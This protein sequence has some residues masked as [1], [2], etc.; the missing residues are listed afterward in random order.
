M[1]NA[2]LVV[3]ATFAIMGGAFAKPDDLHLRSNS[4]L[5]LDSQRGQVLF[6]KNADSVMPIASITKLMTAMVVLD[7]KLPLNQ[8]IVIDSADVDVIKYTRS[9]LR[10]GTRFTRGELLRLA[11][12][13]SENRAAAALGR[14]YPGGLNA[15]VTA[16]NRKAFEL[17]MGSTYFV[18]STGLNSG[19]VSTA[20]D[21][22]KMVKAAHGYRLIRVFSTTAA[23]EVASVGKVRSRSLKKVRSRSLNFVNSNRL[24]RSSSWDIGVS[25]TGFLSEAGRCLVMHANITGKPTIIVLLDSWGKNSRIGDANRIK[26]WMETGFTR[27]VRG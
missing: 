27:K 16:M 13:S 17:G 15:F 4:A 23:H 26:K 9:R 21:L 12:M 19:N 3:C 14:T 6:H 1:K 11:L 22:G 5:I 7:A 20:R 2:I 25:K 24:V 18:D 8:E 10:V